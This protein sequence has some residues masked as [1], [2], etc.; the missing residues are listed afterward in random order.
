MKPFFAAVHH[1]LQAIRKGIDFL[2]CCIQ[3][4]RT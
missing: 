2:T 1:S 3:P 4:W